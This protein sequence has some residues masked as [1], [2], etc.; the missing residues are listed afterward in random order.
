MCDST[1]LYMYVCRGCGKRKELRPSWIH[2]LFKKRNRNS[3]NRGINQRSI[4]SSLVLP[5]R[6][7]NRYRSGPK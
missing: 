2:R 6:P 3:N 4:F 5:I 1:L 7:I